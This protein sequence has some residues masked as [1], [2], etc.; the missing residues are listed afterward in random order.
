[1]IR[2]GVIHHAPRQTTKK[3]DN[4]YDKF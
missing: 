2:T 3:D 1:V 4:M